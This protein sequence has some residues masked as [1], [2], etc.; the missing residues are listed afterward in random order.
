VPAIVV[1]VRCEGIVRDQEGK[2]ALRDP[3]IVALRPDKSAAE[4]DAAERLSELH[5]RG[6]LG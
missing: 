1:T 5:V 3:K 6:R 2:L 4:C